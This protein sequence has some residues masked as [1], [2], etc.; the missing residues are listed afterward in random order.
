[1]PERKLRQAIDEMRRVEISYKD[2]D[3]SVDPYILYEDVDTGEKLLD[4]IQAGRTGSLST[5]R[6]DDITRVD[7]KGPFTP[8]V[9]DSGALRYEKAICRIK[10]G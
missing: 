6:V 4:G 5:F 10:I 2:T 1:M 3:R 7:L 8:V 9:I